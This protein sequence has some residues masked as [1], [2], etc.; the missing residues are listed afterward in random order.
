VRRDPR[1]ELL[2][3]SYLKLVPVL[4]EALELR[5]VRP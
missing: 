3:G 1:V 2:F 5:A 4:F